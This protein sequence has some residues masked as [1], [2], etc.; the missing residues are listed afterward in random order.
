MTAPDEHPYRICLVCMGNICRSPMAE[1]VLRDRLA[2]AG[3]ADR[4]EVDSAGT[5]GW[6]VGDAADA[7]ALATLRGAGYDGSAHRA[8]QFAAEWLASRDLVLA[9]DTDN[10]AVLRRLAAEAGAPRA[11]TA[12]LHLLREWDP[13]AG[14]DLSV[15]DPY[16]GGDAG[17][18]EVL[19]VVERS[20]DGLV[21]DLAGRLA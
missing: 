1:V 5:G 15:P 12:R 20:V 9:L 14:G 10:L 19:A 13:Q 3:L 2:A 6:H 18:R 17:F 4:V 7:R 21:R 8:R 11:V 16:Y